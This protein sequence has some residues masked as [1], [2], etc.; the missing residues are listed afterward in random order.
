MSDIGRRSNRNGHDV[1]GID[2]SPT[3]NDHRVLTVIVYGVALIHFT[4]DRST[5][6]EPL[7]LIEGVG[8]CIDLNILTITNYGVITDCIGIGIEVLA[9]SYAT[10]PQL[11][12]V[13]AQ[14]IVTDG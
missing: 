14:R 1:T 2:T 10:I 13:A 3:I 9:I 7:I 6:I 4:G 5:V 12:I 11:V 8:I